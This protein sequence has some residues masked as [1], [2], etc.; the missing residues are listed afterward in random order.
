MAIILVDEKFDTEP[1][2]F[3]EVGEIATYDVVNKNVE[4]EAIYKLTTDRYSKN[5]IDLTID[6]N[7]CFEFKYKRLID[8]EVNSMVLL[9]DFNKDSNNRTNFVGIR[10]TMALL[11]PEMMPYYSI[12]LLVYYNDGTKDS[13][14]IHGAGPSLNR[15]YL[16]KG[17]YN[18]SSRIFNGKV[19]T[20]IDFSILKGE[21]NLTLSGTKAFTTNEFGVGNVD[22]FD[23]PT[24]IYKIDYDEAYMTVDSTT[25]T[26]RNKIYDTLNALTDGNSEEFYKFE[27][28]KDMPQN[29]AL[30]MPCIVMTLNPSPATEYMFGSDSITYLSFT[31]DLAFKRHHERTIGGAL[32]NEDDL[33]Q[34]Y[35]DNLT[36]VLEAIDWGSINLSERLQ[37]TGRTHQEFN[38][39]MQTYLYGCSVNV[40][41]PYKT[42]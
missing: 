7:F 15:D 33:A 30:V 14:T 24:E 3:V 17:S 12:A 5:H 2:D 13:I 20:G 6:D 31:L 35:L 19:Y 1:S 23:S 10:L 21:R 34:W 26:I 36:H 29:K 11:P 32:Y 40:I 41:I 9:G 38:E 22:M 37:C 39:E 16:F 18:K 27:I 8:V 25:V 4:I 42:Q 28:Y